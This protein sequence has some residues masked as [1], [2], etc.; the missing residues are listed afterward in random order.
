M[1][2]PNIADHHLHFGLLERTHH[3]AFSNDL[4]FHILEL[5]KFKKR[6][7]ELGGGLDIW[8][9][10]LR[11]AEKM[12]A[13]VLPVSLEQPL[14]K[15]ALEELKMLTQE[16][17]ERE[18]YEARLKVQ[19]DHIHLT[20]ARRKALQEAVQEGRQEG[21]FAEKNA[22]VQSYER[23]LNRPETPTKQLASRSLEELT[24]PATQLLADL[25]SQRVS[26]N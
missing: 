7:E 14:V 2:F 6:A 21:R 8:L 16:E 19:F 26:K 10:F 22:T 1:L 9:Y 12:N 25:L 3:F 15:R 18:R 11:H 24:Q 13:E 23:M 4:T 17:I 20:N 5:P